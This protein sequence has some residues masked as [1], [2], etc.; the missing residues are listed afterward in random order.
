MLSQQLKK[1]I[2]ELTNNISEIDSENGNLIDALNQANSVVT[3]SEMEIEKRNNIIKGLKEENQ[4]LVIQLQEKQ[5]DFDYYQSSSQQ[6]NE[7]LR[8][9]LDEAEEEKENLMEQIEKG[10]ENIN[11]LRDELIKYE[12]NGNIILNEKRQKENTFNN[13]IKE[14]QRKEEE[15]INEIE[16]LNIYNNKL[17]QDLENIKSKYDKK[18]KVLQLQYDEASTRIN[19]LIHTCINLKQQVLNLKRKNNINNININ[20]NANN[21]VNLGHYQKKYGALFDDDLFNQTF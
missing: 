10:N 6:E 20:N 8:Q 17:N 5:N 11:Q 14:F 12:N 2:K 15:Y 21:S 3:Q 9:R 19:K 7:M 16:N 18:I 13:Y 1:K 4:Q